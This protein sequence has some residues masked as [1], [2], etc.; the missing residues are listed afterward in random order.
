M[1]YQLWVQR[2]CLNT[3]LLQGI[4]KC[5]IQLEFR[6]TQGCP[7]M[8]EEVIKQA[9]ELASLSPRVRKILNRS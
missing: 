3:S 6:E 7:D 1:H 8:L 2:E 5:R 9:M 4:K